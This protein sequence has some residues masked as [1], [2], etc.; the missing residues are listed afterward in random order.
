M[1]PT[2]LRIDP[3]LAEALAWRTLARLEAAGDPAPIAQHHRRATPLYELAESGDRDAAFRRLAEREVLELR[4]LEPIEAAF[5]ERAELVE[6]IEVL[7]LGEA[8]SRAQEGATCDGNG[9]RIGLRALI[10]RFDDPVRLRGWASHV[11]AHAADTL[12][13]AFQYEP[14]W[15]EGVVAVG[16]AERVHQLWDISLDGRC[17]RAGRAPATPR[18]R[19]EAALAA[20][21]TA[22]APD[23]VGA[24]VE[25]LWSGARPT[26]PELRAWAAE[27]ER[28]GEGGAFVAGDLWS[29]RCPLCSF[30]SHDLAVPDHEIASDVGRE[31]PDW[32]PELGICSRCLDRYAFARIGGSP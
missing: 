4:V 12:D 11:F 19:H 8:S 23:A 28:L 29:G 1:L 3:A 22:T 32:R 13:P 20:L 31:Y 24:T 17:A 15:D 5:A 21:F 18:E 26:F 7:L 27:P 14:G 16:R 2:T 25:R 9:R 30:P 6:Q 10:H